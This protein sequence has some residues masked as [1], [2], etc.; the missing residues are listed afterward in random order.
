MTITE[1]EAPKMQN[2]YTRPF[3]LWAAMVRHVLSCCA[4]ALIFIVWPAKS[5]AAI[6]PAYLS[7]VGGGTAGFNKT[8]PTC[9]PLTITNAPLPVLGQFGQPTAASFSH[10]I[11]YVN[12]AQ[13][14]GTT[15]AYLSCVG[16]GTAGFNKTAPTCG[17]LT[18]T[19]APL[20]V[21]GQFG[22]PTAATFSIFIGY[23]FTTQIAGTSPAYLSCVGGGTAGFN[24]TA[25]TC[26]PLTITNAPLPVL[27]Q[28]GQPT[29]ASF[30][31]FIGYV[32]TTAPVT[33]YAFSPKYF[34][35]SV[36]YAPPGEGPSSITYGTG[37]VTGTT[38]TAAHSWTDAVSLGLS[39]GIASISFGDTFGGSTSSAVDM[40]N[41]STDTTTYKGPASNSINHDY[42]QIIVYLG[43]KINTVVD[44]TG[45]LTYSFDFSQIPSEGYAETGY[46]IP[47][48]C[49]RAN[50]TISAAECAATINLLTS[51]GITAA[52][53]P[54]ILGADPFSDPNTTQSPSASRFVLL[55]SVDFLP[56]PAMPTMTHTENNSSTTSNTSISSYT[57]SVGFAVGGSVGTA[58]Q[59]VLL[60]ASDT[61]TI[62]DSST[63]LNKTGSTTSS[64][65]MLSL[66]TAP[67]TGPAT[68][69]VYLDTIYKTFMFSFQ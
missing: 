14:A 23:V 38:V 68:L 22:Q 57:W 26:G 8:A 17:P 5:F 62:T 64:S 32:Y 11:G 35:G 24:K 20:P 10:L 51:A 4:L 40:E 66:P 55:D 42:D 49:L 43:V 46:P 61:L 45:T 44:Y 27:G 60:S 53:Y 47:V 37:T 33:N 31:V 12:T 9:G 48:G 21:L 30:S 28:F 19:N 7:C 18:I 13:I 1:K 59:T 63:L 69:F 16:G 41:V 56:N 39:I 6:S 34:I 25:P 52:D 65:F 36:I 50:S 29:G 15:A 3:T 67:Y 54:N 58:P 2:L